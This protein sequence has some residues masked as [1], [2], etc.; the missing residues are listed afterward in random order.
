MKFC[1]E[2]QYKLWMMGPFFGGIFFRRAGVVVDT[3]LEDDLK[4]QLKFNPVDTKQI[5]P[6]KGS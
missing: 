3:F 6:K 1:V 5:V 4:G 2:H